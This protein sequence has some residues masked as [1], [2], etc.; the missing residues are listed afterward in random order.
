MTR[1]P[2]DL[3]PVSEK[4]KELYPGRQFL[5]AVWDRG[6][7]KTIVNMITNC[8]LN[9]VVGVLRQ[10]AAEMQDTADVGKLPPEGEA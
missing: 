2:D 10:T 1:V 7:E 9:E 3:D 4:I 6:K 8:D 5:V